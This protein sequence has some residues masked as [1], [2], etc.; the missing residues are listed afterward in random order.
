MNYLGS[1]VLYSISNLIAFNDDLIE[2]QVE[3]P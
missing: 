1:K 2:F 3:L